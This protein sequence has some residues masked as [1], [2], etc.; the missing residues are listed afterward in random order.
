MIEAKIEKQVYGSM[1]N[2]FE[3]MGCPVMIINGM[4]DH[5]HCLFL[6]SPK[7]AMADVIKQVKGATTNFIN[8]EQL[9]TGGF[10]W[11]TGYAAYSVS[12]SV[13][14]RVYRYIKNQKTHHRKRT[15][16]EEYDD[17]LKLYGF[18]EDGG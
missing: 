18:D 14:E 10:K 3:D 12:Q 6:L 4:P 1:R 16:Q 17:Y 15:F 8:D 5:V 7:K 11:Q 2:Q 13:L 9:L